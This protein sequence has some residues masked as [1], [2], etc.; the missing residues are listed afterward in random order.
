MPLVEQELKPFRKHMSSPTVLSGV[1]M[2]RS[3][4]LCVCFL[5]HCCPFVLFLLAIVFSVP[6]QY[7]D[8]DYLFGLQTLLNITILTELSH[9]LHL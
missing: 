7:M 3:L 6:L 5:D 8:Y 9:F 4:A 2:I 1:H